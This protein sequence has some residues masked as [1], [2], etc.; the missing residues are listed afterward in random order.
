MTA[1][2][3]V[4]LG[5]LALLTAGCEARF[6][7]DAAEI[8][9]NATAVGKAE[10]GQL[11]IEAPGFNLKVQIP[12][13][14]RAR[15]NFDEKSGII[16]PDAT[17]SGIHVQGLRSDQESQGDGEVE[18]RFTTGHAPDR[19]M[20]W[21]R[22]P[23]RSTDFSVESAEAGNGGFRLSGTSRPD[24]ERFAL[25]VSPGENGGSDARLVLSDTRR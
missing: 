2:R 17:F 14:I 16:Y 9:E 19:V 23:S 10:E 4:M 15:A 5:A 8:E 3:S 18:L 11:T 1:S 24:G 6:G 13:G 7:N 22:D 12:E 21:Y 20:A 25:T